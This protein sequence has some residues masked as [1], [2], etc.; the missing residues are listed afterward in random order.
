MDPSNSPKTLSRIPEKGRRVLAIG[1]FDL[2]HVGHLRY[3]QYAAA[4]GSYLIV[5][6]STNNISVNIKSKLPVVPEL[7]RLEVVRGVRGVDEAWLQSISTEYTEEAARWIADWCID[8]VVV[9]GGWQGGPRWE[10]LT[11]KL[12]E[13]GIE[14]MFAPATE[15]I[16]T[17][18]LLARIRQYSSGTT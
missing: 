16:S 5:A 3:L 8:L 10:R 4:Q 12:A 1:I 13:S 14:V 2:F 17:T 11:P 15:G 18:E 7:E 9:G 6:V